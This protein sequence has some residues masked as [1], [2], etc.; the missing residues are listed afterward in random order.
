MQVS[1]RGAIFDRFSNISAFAKNIGWD[2]KKASDIVNGRRRPSADEMEEIARALNVE[3]EHT[4][5]SLFFAS[6]STK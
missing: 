4:F 1:L 5:M 2:R 6:L 3:D